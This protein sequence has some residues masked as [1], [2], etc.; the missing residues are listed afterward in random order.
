MSDANYY[1]RFA[2]NKQEEKPQKENKK[3]EVDSSTGLS[4]A[5]V[6]GYMFIGLMI[7]GYL[8]VF[9]MLSIRLSAFS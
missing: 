2:N 8:K 3:Q 7:T 4:I 6:Y 5:K 1:D 9:S